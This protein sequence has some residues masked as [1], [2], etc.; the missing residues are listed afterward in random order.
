ME[1]ESILQ[2]DLEAG[3]RPSLQMVKVTNRNAFPLIDRFDGVPYKF[4]PHKPLVIPPDVAGH[5][6]AWPAEREVRLAHMSK[7]YAWNRVTDD[8]AFLQPV[9]GSDDTRTLAEKY[10]DNVVIE[11]QQFDLVA[12]SPDTTFPEEQ[13]VTHDLPAPMAEFGDEEGGTHVGKR[14][15]PPKRLNM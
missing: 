1:P 8:M 6:F 3:R 7:R 9:S 4:L 2:A 10:C 14:K 13:E 5:F 15:G 12:R 11:V